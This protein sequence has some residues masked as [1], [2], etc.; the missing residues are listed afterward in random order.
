[1]YN[2]YTIIKEEY[3]E[4]IKTKGVLLKHNKTGAKVELFINDDPNKTFC[5]SFKTPCHNSTGIPHIIEH[6]VLCGSRKYPVKDPFLEL[7]KGSL[8]TFLN[9]MTYPDKTLYPVASCNDKDFQN[10]M[11]IY[12][13]AVFFP[14]ILNKKELFMQEGWHYEYDKEKDE[15]LYNGV[16]YNEMK[17]VFSSSDALIDLEAAKVLFPD[18]PYRFESGGDPKCIPDLTYEEFISFYKKYYHPSNAYI[19]LYGNC[20]MEEKLAYIDKEYLSLFDKIEVDSSIAIQKPFDKI[21]ESTIKYPLSKN[22]EEQNNTILSYNVVFPEAFTPLDK[23]TLDIIVASILSSG[24]A[25]MEDAL[26]EGGVGNVIS[27]GCEYGLAQ[28][29]LS[30]VAKGAN[31]EDKDKFIDIIEKEFKKYA[32]EGLDKKSLEGLI[33]QFDFDVREFGG[34][35]RGMSY[36]TKSLESWLYDEN[37]PFGEFSFIEIAKTLREKLD[38][39]YFE[40]FIEKYIVNNNH[41]AV[42]VGIPSKTEQEEKEEQIKLH[43]KEIKNSLSTSELNKIIEDEKNL[44]AYQEAKDKEEDLNKLPK[45]GKEDLNYDYF[46]ASNIVKD[47]NGIKI[48][49]HNYDRNN[50]LGEMLYFDLKNF[51]ADDYKYI[52]LMSYLLGELGTEKYTYDELDKEIDITTGGMQF[53]LLTGT[54]VKGKI[55]T[56]FICGVKALY[57]KA[58][59]AFALLK[60]VIFKTNY[61]DKKIVKKVLQT[62][63]KSL[64]RSLMMGGHSVS[65][66]RALSYISYDGLINENAGG[67]LHYHFLKDLMNSFDEKYDELIAKFN[68]LSKDIFVKEGLLASSTADIKGLSIFDKLISDFSFELK[69]KNDLVNTDSF[70]P[71]ILNE[72]F[73]API[74][75]NYCSCVGIMPPSK[76]KYSGA[77]YVLLNIINTEYLWNNVRVLGGAYGSFA[78]LSV[79][80]VFTLTS[81][82]DPNC[83]NTYDIYNKLCDFLTNFNPT[84]EEFIKYIIGAVG[85]IDAPTTPKENG[86]KAMADYLFGLTDDDRRNIKKEIVD[87][88]LDDIKKFIPVL[89]ELIDQNIICTIGSKKKVEED[90]DIFKTTLDLLK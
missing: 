11:D 18:S 13:D 80:G 75:V 49:D 64:E 21:K 4:S 42:I 63:L 35:S 26:L 28:S 82:R 36:L 37:N 7:M 20:D 51:N 23:Q 10:L 25:P 5:I 44:K 74:D 54:N 1:M 72:G 55:Y 19:T 60:E 58:S 48:I 84:N 3:L 39:D 2:N 31:P 30:I 40:K 88:T 32:K 27:G 8:N 14:N 46:K 71:S 61:D 85:V 38:T 41:K 70:T 45:L 50:V 9:A 53:N 81:Y 17:G 15:L 6:S 69:D 86:G 57:E 34:A 12:L 78:R 65:I 90:K 47:V 68:S 22:Q 16:V 52:S 43:L 59:D 33:N 29:V 79:E 83:K 77:T 73:T 62:R 66:K 56:Y 76:Y 87:A 24:L 67:I 89:K